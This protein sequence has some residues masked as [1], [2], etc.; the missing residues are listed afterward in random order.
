MK[1][2]YLGISVMVL[3]FAVLALCATSS[4]CDE[5]IDAVTTASKKFYYAKS[6]LTGEMLQELINSHHAAFVLS[7]TN[8]DNSP[9]AGFFI[10]EMP[11]NSTIKFGLANNQTRQ[12]I[13][14]TKKAVLTVYKASP[15]ADRKTRHQGARLILR[16]DEKKSKNKLTHKMLIMEIVKVLPLG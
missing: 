14:R 2:L 4:F 3:I 9:N 6:S 10:P 1:K 8:P 13:E 7:T 11:S 5:D 16:L 12:N 15:D